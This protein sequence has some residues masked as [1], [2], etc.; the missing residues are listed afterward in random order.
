MLYKQHV[1]QNRLYV[2][3]DNAREDNEWPGNYTAGGHH[4]IHLDDYLG[5]QKQYRILHKL[6]YVAVKIL[7][8]EHSDH[9]QNRELEMT[10]RLQEIAQRDLDIAEYCCLPLDKFRIE[11]PNGSHQCFFYP[12]AGPLLAYLMSD[13]LRKGVH[14]NHEYAAPELILEVG[15]NVGKNKLMLEPEYGAASNICALACMIFRIHTEHCLFWLEYDTMSEA[16]ERFHAIPGPLP[17]AWEIEDDDTQRRFLPVNEDPK[18]Q[19]I[20]EQFYSEWHAHCV[21]RSGGEK[22]AEQLSEKEI[23][24]MADLILTIIK[25]D[26]KERPSAKQVLRHPWFTSDWD[27]ADAD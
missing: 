5:D 19:T 10:T 6:G 12:V 18:R 7:T 16:F 9:A 23:D 4:P 15:C 27:E 3:A 2:H 8:A 26:P 24:I 21:R 1:G 20:R 14:F 17:E 22:S 11:G 13:Q 25:Y